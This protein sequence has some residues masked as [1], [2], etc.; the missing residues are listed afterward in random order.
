MIIAKRK[1]LIKKYIE[2]ENSQI[3]KGSVKVIYHSGVKRY[4]VS[5]YLQNKKRETLKLEYDD[6]EKILLKMI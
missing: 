4:H 5:Y 1:D 3:V 6:A 2:E